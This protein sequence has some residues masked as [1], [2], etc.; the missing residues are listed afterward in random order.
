MTIRTDVAPPKSDRERTGLIVIVYPIGVMLISILLN[1]VFGVT[2]THIALPSEQ[3][4]LGLIISGVL[5]VINHTWLMTATE[6][7][8]VRFGMY[9]TPEEWAASGRHPEEVLDEGLRELERRHNIHRNTTENTIYF[10]FLALVFAVVS[11]SGIA[12]L[13][14]PITYSISRLGYTYS[15]LMGQ[16]GARGLFMS[17]SLM[18]MYGMT[19]YLVIS[20]LV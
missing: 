4:I 20:L 16:T 2:P 15:Y 7:T 19:S 3:V 12:S 14:W 13:M 5:L 10:V 17:L 9:A 18:A 6:L 8:R 1:W 11:P